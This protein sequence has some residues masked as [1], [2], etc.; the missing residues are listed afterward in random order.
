MKRIMLSII[1]VHYKV[2]DELFNCIKSILNSKPKTK[3]EIIVVDNDEE[4]II[5]KDLKD[6]YPKVRY[7]KTP[8]NIGFGAGCNLGAKFAKGNYL[9]F[10]NPDTRVLPESLDNL[11]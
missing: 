11:Y 3:Y 6:R 7:I 9:F 8:K 5:E 10:L 4:N 1:I 2:K